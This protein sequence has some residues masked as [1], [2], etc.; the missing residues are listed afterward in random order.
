VGYGRVGRRIGDALAAKGTHFV[1][2]DRNREVVEDLRSR[3][4]HA[5]SGDA[6]DP[7][8]MAQTHVM[9]ARL[10]VIATPDSFAVR[11]MMEIARILNPAIET[12]VRTHSEEE[13]ELLRKEK[14]DKVF[15]GEHELALG[16]T[17]HVMER[18]AGSWPATS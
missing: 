12:V 1:V 16:M 3:G 8:V 9:R 7:V 17:R 6:S 15:M 11:K 18:L 5:V 10:L 4:L 2:A 13:A 14:A